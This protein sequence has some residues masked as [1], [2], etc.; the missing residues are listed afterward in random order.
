MKQ[1]TSRSVLQVRQV[2]DGSGTRF[3]PVD[4]N[5]VYTA[6]EYIYS[7]V[8]HRPSGDMGASENQR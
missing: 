4:T 7:C 5:K 1:K 8:Y 2:T 6:S 3:P